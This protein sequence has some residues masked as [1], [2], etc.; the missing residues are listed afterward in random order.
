[1]AL[2]VKAALCVCLGFVGGM[3]WLLSGLD[4]R[5]RTLR[6]P[7]VACSAA[8]DS[9][10]VVALADR[11][12]GAASTETPT[13][14]ERFAHSNRFDEAVED[15]PVVSV[16]LAA[17]EPTE[18]DVAARMV[19]P[20]LVYDPP[21]P[22][23]VPDPVVAA[24]RERAVRHEAAAEP[25]R[26]ML[27]ASGDSEVAAAL[28]RYVVKRGD[29]LM[30]ILRAEMSTD[31]PEV[32][33]LVCLLNPQIKERRDR[34]LVGETLR[35]PSAGTVA[36]VVAGETEPRVACV[37]LG[38]TPNERQT[39]P[40]R[41]YTIQRNDSLS[42]IARKHLKDG[43]RWREILALNRSLDPDRIIP[44]ARIRLPRLLGEVASR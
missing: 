35:L 31:D 23:T 22:T 15:I 37:D 38:V 4:V 20:P 32:L 7:L 44:G 3:S 28:R 42:S 26:S 17:L 27:S 36:K 2:N 30:K 33:E 43:R 40:F 18:P 16:R 1:M 12:N 10:L 34:I 19:L 41:W 8:G 13:W 9:A 11:A 29:T 14:A 21:R 25:G 39:R 24:V 6:S 5:Q